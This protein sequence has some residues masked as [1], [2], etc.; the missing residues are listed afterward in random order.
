[1]SLEPN[2]ITWRMLHEHAAGVGLCPEFFDLSGIDPDAPVT[3]T[4]NFDQGHE[5]GCAIVYA[6]ELRK[7]LKP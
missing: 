4:C 3:C 6:H 7:T 2:P 1:V 5:P